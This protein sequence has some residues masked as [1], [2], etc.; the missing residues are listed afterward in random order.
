MS[1]ISLFTA[2][3]PKSFDFK[4][5]VLRHVLIDRKSKYTASGGKITS[6]EAWKQWMRELLQDNQFSK[7]THNSYAWRIQNEDGSVEEWRNDDGE[8]WAW[9]CIL[10]ELQRE[11][12]INGIVVVTRY[13]GG[14]KLHGDRFR[15]VIEVSR[16]FLEKV[17]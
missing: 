7:A 8:K 13:Y 9:K 11:Q 5:K 12:I 15:N 17:F 16:E 2:P 10:R 3:W 6:K 14:V 1:R 4:R